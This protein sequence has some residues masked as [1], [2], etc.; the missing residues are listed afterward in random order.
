MERISRA[1][2]YSNQAHNSYII[3][4]IY[5][6][7]AWPRRSSR[8][9]PTT[10]PFRSCCRRSRRTPMQRPKSW[11]E[12]CMKLHWLIQV[13]PITQ[14][15]FRLHHPRYRSI[16]QTILQII[17]FRFGYL[18]RCTHRGI[19]SRT[20]WWWYIILLSISLEVDDV[21]DDAKKDDD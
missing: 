14:Q 12:C 1:Q 4:N 11:L 16:F 8:S 3:I 19:S 2:A 9:I 17:Q 6:A 5:L 18:T 15:F 10:L 21:K 13:Y 20:W 7:W